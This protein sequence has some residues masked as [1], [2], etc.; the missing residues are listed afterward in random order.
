MS[1]NGGSL[2]EEILR[3]LYLLSDD[4][5]Q[6]G[7]SSVFS[8]S[9]G[10][11]AEEFDDAYGELAADDLVGPIGLGRSEFGFRLWITPEGIRRTEELGLVD[12]ERVRGRE[13]ARQKILLHLRELYKQSGRLK[14]VRREALINVGGGNGDAR[15][16]FIELEGDGFPD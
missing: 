10:A 13:Q 4:P 6:R 9:L 12:A 16:A 14:T 2:Q 1:S 7:W 3:R 15:R 11:S 5:D 8:T